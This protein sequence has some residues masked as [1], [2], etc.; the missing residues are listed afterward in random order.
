MLKS[1]G[2]NIISAAPGAG[3]SSLLTL[4]VISTR[5]SEVGNE[6]VA[7]GTIWT[8]PMHPEIRRDAP[9]SCPICGM[10]LEPLEPSLEEGPNLELIDFTRR[11]WVSA[12]LAVPLVVLAWAPSYSA[13]DFCRCAFRCGC[14]SRLRPRSCCGPPSRSSSVAGSRSRPASSIC[15]R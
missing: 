7:E 8:C 12:V 15:S 13:G 4:I 1:P 2:P 6:T 11:L 5:P 14:S 10:A 9:G 3:P